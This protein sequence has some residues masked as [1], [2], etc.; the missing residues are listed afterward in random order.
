MGQVLADSVIG[1]ILSYL[2]LITHF[3]NFNKG[4]IDTSDIAYCVGMMTLGLYLTYQVVESQRWK[5]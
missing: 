1:Q 3:E 2:S 5:S 4:L